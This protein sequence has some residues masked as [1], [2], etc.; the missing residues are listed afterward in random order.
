MIFA[1]DLDFRF[2]ISD[3]RLSEKYKSEIRNQKS[4]IKKWQN[5]AYQK[6]PEIFH[7]LRC[8]NATIFFQ[9]SKAISKSMAINLL[10]H[11]RSKIQKL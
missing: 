5:Q 11:H 2:K 6:E 4:E 9:S 3:L 8:Q 7:L 1:G 10:K